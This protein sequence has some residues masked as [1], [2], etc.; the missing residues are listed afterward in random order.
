VDF[1]EYRAHQWHETLDLQIKLQGAEKAIRAMRGGI[2]PRANSNGLLTAEIQQIVARLSS[3]AGWYQS[4]AQEAST[5]AELGR[6]ALRHGRKITARD[7]LVQAA[8]LYFYGQLYAK[9][10]HPE[11]REGSVRLIECYNQAGVL[12]TPP[13]ERVGIPFRDTILPAY[14][15]IPGG[16]E[17]KPCLIM[18]GGADTV[19]EECHHWS[20][21]FLT[22]G[23]ATL[24][25]DGPGQGESHALLPMSA[26][27]EKA[28]S[29]I[30]EWLSDHP[31]I[32]G[33]RIGV[34]G[35]STGGYLAARSLAFDSKISLGV[36]VG[37]FYDARLF[38]DWPPPTQ[39]A[40]QRLFWLNNLSETVEYV[41][42][43]VTL[44][45]F[46][47]RIERP[48]L[49]VHGVRDHLV[50]KA[51]IQAMVDEASNNAELWAYED[52]TH[53]V[54]NKLDVAAPRAAD[55]I[56]EHL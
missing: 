42:Q 24:A 47:R 28:V 38:P 11:K 2:F 40:F 1:Y 37:G 50:P 33:R 56:A 30:R 45:S 16:S 39:E 44:K 27:Y 19:K 52:G 49:I 22:R 23:V 26:D 54:W 10:G 15:R 35:C 7:A 51:E 31:A 6:D 3:M 34:W 13:V 18:L 29:T 46:M 8:Y 25:V 4:W 41:R 53:S 36:S 21:H 17:K 32:D 5:R 14:L 43:N 55:W 9:F 48:F 20:E 12:L